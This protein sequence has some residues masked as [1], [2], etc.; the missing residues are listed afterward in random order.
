MHKRERNGW[1]IEIIYQAEEIIQLSDQ[2]DILL[3]SVLCL[4]VFKSFG[5]TWV[6]C[7]FIIC[8]IG[9]PKN[10]IFSRTSVA[11]AVL[12]TPL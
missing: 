9:L 11:G 1:N 10:I 12:K 3:D 7:S 4:L 2:I 6:P 5:C 8:Y